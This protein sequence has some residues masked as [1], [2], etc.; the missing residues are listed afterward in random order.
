MLRKA[1]LNKGSQGQLA[2]RVWRAHLSAA[3]C[4]EGSS[5]LASAGSASGPGWHIAGSS[6]VGEKHGK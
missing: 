3:A 1:I 6:E 4:T 2:G 5:E